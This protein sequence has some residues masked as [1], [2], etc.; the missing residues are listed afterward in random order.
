MLKL[1]VPDL[2][3]NSYF[4][5]EAAVQLGFFREQGLDVSL[6]LIFPVNKAYEALREGEI[7]IVA[8]SAHSALAA[9]PNFRDVR[10]LCAQSQGMYWFLVMHSDFAPVRGDLSVVRGKRI[11]AAPWVE[12]G[13]RQALTEAGID[14]EAEQVKI[15]PVPAPPGG[16][17][18]N[19]GLNAARALEERLI[20]GF[21]ANGMA[22]EIATRSGVGTV[23]FDARRDASP[24]GAFG[25]TF[26]SVATRASLP[27]ERPQE[28]AA[29]VRAIRAAQT[30][31]R[32]DVSMAAKVGE[33]L[34]PEREASLI[35][36]IVRRDLP[37]YDAAISRK[38]VE[39]M[40]RFART[41]GL[42]DRDL[43]YEDVVAEELSAL[44][45]A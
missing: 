18:V 2:V 38:T 35:T 15:A 27:A 20:D 44:W 39:G 14:I 8:G 33:G 43:V 23:V 17:T 9:F 36:D 22:A 40:S 37:F 10:L 19:F 29:I 7:D 26:A 41:L 21:W 32:G 6:Q 11:G 3:S 25:Y 12:M 42:V 45:T 28:A 24:A 4:P 5:A 34:F 30:A 1:A 31:L 13:L 16:G